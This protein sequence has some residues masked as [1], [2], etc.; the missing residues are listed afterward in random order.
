MGLTSESW[1]IRAASGTYCHL[2]VFHCKDVGQLFIVGMCYPAYAGHVPSIMGSRDPLPQ[3][4]AL[5]A[6]PY[7]VHY[8]LWAAIS[9]VIHL[10]TVWLWWLEWT[11]HWFSTSPQMVIKSTTLSWLQLLL[12]LQTMLGMV[13]GAMAWVL[14]VCLVWMTFKTKF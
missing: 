7:Q 9:I 10:K 4:L 13:F 5:Q 6:H 12:I 2:T 11:T 3:C 8:C 1:E 14:D